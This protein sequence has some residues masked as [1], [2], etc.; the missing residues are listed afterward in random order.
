MHF[1]IFSVSLKTLGWL[2]AFNSSKKRWLKQPTEWKQKRKRDRVFV[3]M[4]E[5]EYAGK[6]ER[7]CACEWVCVWDRKRDWELVCVR[8]SALISTCNKFPPFPRP[9]SFWRQAYFCSSWVL[10][11][12]L[13]LKRFVYV[14]VPYEFYLCVL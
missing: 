11:V 9:A 14:S 10:Y 7:E 12:F 6:R 5:R 4:R 8:D 2:T 13:L 3:L 1:N